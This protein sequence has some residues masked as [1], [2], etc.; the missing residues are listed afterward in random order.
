MQSRIFEIAWG[1]IRDRKMR[2]SAPRF[3]F[4]VSRNSARNER[5][6]RRRFSQIFVVFNTQTDVPRLFR[7]PSS[8]HRIF[9]AGWEY[10]NEGADEKSRGIWDACGGDD[11]PRQFIWRD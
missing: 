9:A 8:A 6:M 11:R 4:D 3:R 1:V 10:P 5:P 2:Q 7:S